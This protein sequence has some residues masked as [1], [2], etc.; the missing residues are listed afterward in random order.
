MQYRTDPKSGARVSALGLGCMRLPGAQRGRILTTSLERLRTERAD[1]CLR[2]Q[3]H[4][5]VFRCMGRRLDSR[6]DVP[7][8]CVRHPGSRAR[9]ALGDIPQACSNAALKVESR[10]YPTARATCAMDSSAAPSSSRACSRRRR[11][12]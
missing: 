4:D 11:R 8:L 6:T 3:P 1:Y 7:S 5:G 10:P 12:T 9:Q 2:P